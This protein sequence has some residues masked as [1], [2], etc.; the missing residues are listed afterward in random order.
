MPD[1]PKPMKQTTFKCPICSGLMNSIPGDGTRNL[2]AKGVILRC[3]NADCLP[4]ENVY[5]YGTNDK[6]AYIIACQKYRP[7]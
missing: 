1:E 6:E 3:D 5:G 7:N 4:H 2:D